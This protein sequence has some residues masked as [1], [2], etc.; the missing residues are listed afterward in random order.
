MGAIYLG[1]SVVLGAAVPWQATRLW[2]D[3]T[4]ARAV[5]LHK[6]SITYL[7]LLF[8]AIAVDA[9]AIIPVG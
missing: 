8:L 3:G 6:S 1:A 2:R 9:L 5:R 7:T 4:T